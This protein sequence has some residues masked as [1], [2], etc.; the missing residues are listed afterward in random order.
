MSANSGINMLVTKFNCKFD[1]LD[2]KYIENP[3]DINN[4]IVSFINITY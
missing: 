2:Q 4:H 3:I 1:F